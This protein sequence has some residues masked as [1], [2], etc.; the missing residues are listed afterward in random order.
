MPNAFLHLDDLAA[1]SQIVLALIAALALIG[2]AA[3]ALV[4]RSAT[5]QTL[6]YNY[7]HRFADPTLIPFRQKT[8]DLFSVK[9]TTEDERWQ[10]FRE[11]SL[12]EQVEALV[13]PNLVEEL[14]GMYNHKLL[15]RKI[16]KDFFGFTAHQLWSEGWWFTQRSREYYAEYY[17]QWEKML[18]DMGFEL[19]APSRRDR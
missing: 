13:L 14:A 10:A 18:V 6:T 7:T 5:R 15:N 17:T 4:T 8:T 1:I 12:T 19:P 11:S 3:Q 2:A 16:A 9:G